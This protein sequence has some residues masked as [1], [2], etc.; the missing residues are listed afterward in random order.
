MARRAE[1]EASIVALLTAWRA[2]VE[3]DR[4]SL[5]KPVPI[6]FG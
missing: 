2:G 3:D 5:L 1:I 4:I 6:G